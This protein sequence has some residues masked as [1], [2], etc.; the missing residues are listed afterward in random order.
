MRTRQGDFELGKNVLEFDD[1]KLGEEVWG[2]KVE[3]MLDWWNAVEDGDEQAHEQKEEEGQEDGEE[4][5]DGG[6]GEAVEEDIPK[7]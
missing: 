2:P 3:K 7:S 6:K 5:K 1:L 4:K